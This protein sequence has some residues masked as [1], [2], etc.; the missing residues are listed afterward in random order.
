[1]NGLYESYPVIMNIVDGIIW[2][3]GILW[4]IATYIGAPLES[5]KKG[6]H[7]SGFPGLAFLHFL[8][9][10]LLSP[11]KWLAVTALLDISVTCLPIFLI[12]EKKKDKKI[13]SKDEEIK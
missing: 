12:K 10:G 11:Y 13:K 3:V 8:V 6:Y 7:V 2:L 1:M 9:A 4:W 5:K